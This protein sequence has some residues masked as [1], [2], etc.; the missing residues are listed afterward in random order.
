MGRLP[1]RPAGSVRGVVDG[2]LARSEPIAMPPRRRLD[3]ERP[4]RKLRVNDALLLRPSAS[5]LVVWAGDAAP[6]MGQR[7]LGRGVMLARHGPIATPPCRCSDGESSTRQLRVGTALLLRPA[8]PS[9]TR[10]HRRGGPSI[11]FLA[12]RDA[13]TTRGGL[14]SSGRSNGAPFHQCC[15]Q[16]RDLCVCVRSKHGLG[17]RCR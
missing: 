17:T 9:A 16:P 1:A 13:Q 10:R 7:L 14:G 6:L 2:L 4:A 8:P 5:T 12:L 11:E 3:K 15:R